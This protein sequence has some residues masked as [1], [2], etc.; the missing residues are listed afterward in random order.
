VFEPDN[1]EVHHSLAL[2]LRALGR[3][4]D[5]RAAFGEALRLQPESTRLHNNYGNLLRD[6]GLFEDACTAY[7]RA[8][9]LQPDYPEAVTNLATTL[10]DQGKLD[11]AVAE[12]ERAISLKPELNIAHG[13]LLFALSY[14]PGTTLAALDAAHRAWND[15]FAAPLKPPTWRAH[16]RAVTRERPRLGFVSADFNQ[17]PV[18]YFMIQLFEKLKRRRAEVFCY[19]NQTRSDALTTRFRASASE[20]RSIAGLSD[21]SVAD[22]IR[23]DEVDILF[24]LSGFMAGN[25]LMVFARKPAPVQVTWFGYMATTGLEAI[26]YILADR[27]H[28]PPQ[29]E[30]YY[31]EKVVRLPDSLVCFDPPADAPVV[32]AL[33]ALSNGYVTFG[34]FNVLCKITPQV[35]ALWSRVLARL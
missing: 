13:N 27:H 18:G 11:E 20:W 33:P 4:G 35:V 17:H 24:D 12:Y 34:S 3:L 32:T 14:C 7:R 10:K 30:P 22:R 28:I 8:L 1:G 6:L 29:S 15:R 2:A 9:M 25:R 26:D 23:A 21:A 19:T 31:C 16:R 5:A